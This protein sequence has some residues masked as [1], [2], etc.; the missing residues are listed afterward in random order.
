MNAPGGCDAC[1]MAVGQASGGEQAAVAKLLFLRSGPA[2]GGDRLAGEIDDG[3][4]AVDGLRPGP[5]LPSG[6]HG[7]NDTR[8]CGGALF[9]F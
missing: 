6:V 2:F 9:E 7:T 4:G 3:R 1:R 5:A 8:G